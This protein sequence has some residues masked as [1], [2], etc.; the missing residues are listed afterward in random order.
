MRTHFLLIH[1]ST[2]H[3]LG[4]AELNVL[5]IAQWLNERG[6]KNI[7]I[8]SEGSPLSKHASDRGLHTEVIHQRRKYINVKSVGELSRFIKRTQPYVIFIH[9][10]RDI[11]TVVLAKI[12]SRQAV[13]LIYLQHMQIGVKKKDLYH[14][15]L[16]KHLDVWIAPLPYLKKNVLH[17]T[18]IDE[19][20]ICEIPFGIEI[21]RFNPDVYSK[22]EARK[23]FNLPPDAFIAGIIGRLDYGKGQEYLIRAVALL[24]QENIDFHAFIVG[25]ETKW[26]SQH[27]GLKLHQ[28][29]RELH[30]EE[31]IHFQPFTFDVAQAFAAMDVFCLTSLSETFGMVTIEA[32]SMQLPIIATNSAG[33]PDIIQNDVNGLLVPPQ[34]AEAIADAILRLYS[35]HDL[36]MK[37]AMQAR[38]DVEEKFTNMNQC[39]LLEEC[40]GKI[41]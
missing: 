33:T 1:L 16:Y 18:N 6:H 7:I 12:L 13:I 23:R 39:E 19:A 10:S 36:S 24:Q 15:W 34:N 30:I 32:M 14:N 9:S 41:M 27:Y 17:F 37:I 38:K 31:R 29:A 40:I 4:G 26:E 11:L 5:N 28:L 35:D 20:C 3:S 2:S 25:D 22:H 8:A 21:D